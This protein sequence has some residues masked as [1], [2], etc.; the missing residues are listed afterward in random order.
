MIKIIID[1]NGKESN[2]KDHYGFSC[3]IDADS[4]FHIGCS[5]LPWVGADIGF[6]EKL[7]KIVMRPSET[8]VEDGSK[9]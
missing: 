8:A 3:T 1:N 2:K 5:K 4:S 7:T 6:V 9:G